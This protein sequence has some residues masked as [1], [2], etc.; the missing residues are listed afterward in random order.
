MTVIVSPR[1]RVSTPNPRRRGAFAAGVLIVGVTSGL[2]GIVLTLLLHG[3]QHLAFGY[4][5]NTFLVGVQAASYPRRVAAVALGGLVVSLGWWWH[6]AHFEGDA[7]SV[8]HALR[9]RGVG[10]P[11]VATVTDAV[12]QVVAVG[13][14]ASLGR[15]GA[16]RQTA[17]A[18]ASWVAERL[19]LGDPDRRVLVACGAGAGLA[20]VYNVPVAGALFTLEVLL[21]SR[22]AR[23]VIAAVVTS[24][25]ATVATWPVLSDKPAYVVPRLAFSWPVMGW[26]LVC[27]PLAAGV[28]LAFVRYADAMRRHAPSGWRVVPVMTIGFAALGL[29][30]TAYPQLLGNGKG[31]A[32]LAF[33]GAAGLA[34]A[35]TLT[36]LKPVVTGGCLALGAI[37]GLLTPALA[38]GACLGAAAGQLV[39]HLGL[40]VSPGA[41]ALVGA[42]A[43]LAVTQR[44]L[45]TSIVFPAELLHTGLALAVPVIVATVGAVLVT[46]GLD[47]TPP[48]AT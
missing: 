27:A 22:A 39:L 5:E 15:E 32:E 46:R 12:L 47:R 4:T 24:V 3:V 36:F 20:A 21:V 23:T 37:G 45:L 11:F 1:P 42:S 13:T 30:A 38:T 16:P 25:I 7:V 31:P 18:L 19:R 6:R 35:L 29:V 2:T 34:L 17:A 33:T 14:G 40:A 28:G 8:T 43:V 44:A 48:R 10:L 41:C 9:R 26:A